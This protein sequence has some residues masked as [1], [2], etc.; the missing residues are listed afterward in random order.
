MASL[1]AKDRVSLCQFS[2]SDG[3][4]CRTPRT[5]KNPHFCFDHAQ[6]EARAFAEESLSK[7]LAY[8]FS[9]DYLFLRSQHCPGPPNPRR[10]P[11]R[12][13]TQSRPHR[14]LHGANPPAVHPNRPARIH[15]HLR[16]R[17]LAQIHPPLRQLQLQPPLPQ[18]PETRTR[19]TTRIPPTATPARP[20]HT[21]GPSPDQL[22]RPH[23]RNPVRPTVRA[24]PS[25]R[26][27]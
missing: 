6:K 17:R 7:D 24:R 1:S 20:G 13:K 3:R 5:G 23:S 2:F 12:C 9:G 15:Q 27:P 25:A 14:R 18:R 19:R 8:F 21:T 10:C 26:L 4:R 11:R 16:H 22:A